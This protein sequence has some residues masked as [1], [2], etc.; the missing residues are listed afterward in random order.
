MNK[1]IILLIT[2]T[3][4]F[5]EKFSNLNS[6]K[7][8]DGSVVLNVEIDKDK[9]YYSVSKNNKTIIDKSQLGIIAD[10]F[11]LSEN[12]SLKNVQRNS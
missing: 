4:I 6:I 8:P 3:V 10:K 12:L 5:G 9:I 2:L 1:I 7:S 11:D